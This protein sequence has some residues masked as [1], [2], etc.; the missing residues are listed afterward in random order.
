MHVLQSPFFSGAENVVC[1]IIE[2][3]KDS[4]YEMVYCSPDGPIRETVEKKGIAFIPLA[5]I[6][7]ANLRKAIQ[8]YKPDIIH[9]HD[10]KAS[11]CAALACSLPVVSHMHVNNPSNGKLDV[12]SLI[13]SFFSCRFR[14][15]FWVSNSALTDFRY[16]HKS[17]SEKSSVLYNVIDIVKLKQRMAED[18]NTYPYDAV[19]LGRLTYQKNPERALGVIKKV[20]EKNSS[21]QFA[22]IGSGPLEAQVVSELK[23]DE[24]KGRVKYLGYMDNPLKALRD[25]K[26]MLM[27]SRFEG[28]PM[29]VLEAMALGVP[30]VSTP[31]DGVAD[32]IKDGVNGFLSDSDDMLSE[33]LNE[34]IINIDIRAELS[35]AAR[36]T[37]ERLMNIDVYKEKLTE[38]YASCR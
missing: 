6:N 37:A 27:T 14:H 17:I 25:S 35:D 12:K 38:V 4:E 19:V 33:K 34:L 3:F 18:K 16:K 24:Y 15:V 26:A 1:Q 23:K 32:L 10:R 36:Q 5:E 28:T 2:M 20:L 7:V 29:T 21:A 9:A 13:Y 22:V 30:V 8:A 31:V 11:I